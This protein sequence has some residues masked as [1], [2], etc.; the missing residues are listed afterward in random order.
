MIVS[1]TARA[2]LAVGLLL[3]VMGTAS[4]QQATGGNSK[5]ASD[6]AVPPPLPPGV[7]P[8]TGYVIGAHDV[9]SIVF[10]RDKDMNA[11]VTVRPD[12]KISLPLINEIQAAGL[13]PEQLRV[14]V[15]EAAS[16]FLED[17]TAS[18]VVKEIKS[19]NVFI[20]GSVSKPGTYPLVGEMNVLQLIAL[21]GG[22]LEWADSKNIVVIQTENGRPKYR[23]F[24]YNEVINQKNLEQNVT[25]KPNDTV[26]VR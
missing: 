9:L 24:N 21:A 3:A 12:G 22:L 26:V 18:V 7:T 1:S 19:R 23:K 15:A 14:A 16:K 25:L 10:W 20:T 6:K 5:A 8:P 2:T 17:P 13:T 11:D 4:G